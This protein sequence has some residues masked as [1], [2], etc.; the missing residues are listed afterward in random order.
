MYGKK[1]LKLSS[2]NQSYPYNLTTY[3]YCVLTINNY[4]SLQVY[5][6][7][8]KLTNIG[9]KICYGSDSIPYCQPI[10]LTNGFKLSLKITNN[11]IFL[12]TS[13]LGD[14]TTTS[15]VYGTTSG[16]YWIGCIEMERRDSFSY[17]PKTGYN[18][19]THCFY[20]SS[21]PNYVYFP[22]LKSQNSPLVQVTGS[23][24]KLKIKTPMYLTK[25]CK[26]R[27]GGVNQQTIECFATSD[28]S[29]NF[30]EQIVGGK[31]L[32]LYR[33]YD[34]IDN[35]NDTKKD[36]NSSDEYKVVSTGT[37]RHLWKYD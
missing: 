5:E 7:Y 8:D 35:Q 34:N 21:S 10:D 31:L 14:S 32:G 27:Y 4:I 18:Y 6:S 37:I 19:P 29:S 26:D 17:D 16:N 28:N 9:Q 20:S 15:P 33:G 2:Q 13:T 36:D 22:I 25:G 1:Q 24:A 3:K 11:H 30:V 23:N 12:Q